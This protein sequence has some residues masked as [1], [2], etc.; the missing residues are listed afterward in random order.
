ML[1]RYHLSL[2][3]PA[4]D[5]LSILVSHLRADDVS[6]LSLEILVPGTD[7]VIL[8]CPVPLPAELK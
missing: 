8:P 2:S 5:L 3:C 7:P 6:L 4:F 1:H